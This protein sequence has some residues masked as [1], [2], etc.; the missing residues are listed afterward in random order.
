MRIKESCHFVM[1]LPLHSVS[2]IELF[3]CVGERATL[4]PIPM[5]SRPLKN[6]LHDLSGAPRCSSMT[7]WKHNLRQHIHFFSPLS[8]ESRVA[9]GW[10]LLVTQIVAFYASR[11]SSHN[12]LLQSTAT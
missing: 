6:S 3:K 8:P 12:T 11:P 9:R 10:L 5:Q 4:E 7:S 1:K 2:M